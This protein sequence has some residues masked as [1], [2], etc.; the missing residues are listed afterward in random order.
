MNRKINSEDHWKK[1][2]TP[3]EFHI[4]REKGTEPAFIGKLLYNKKRG[5]YVCAACGDK[6]FSSGAKY[7]SGTGWPSFFAPASGKSVKTQPDSAM[8]TEATCSRC[9]SHLGHVFDDGPEPTGQRF[10]INSAA[11]KFKEKKSRP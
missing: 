1:K 5:V 6:L 7:D 2:L 9:G 3:E 11:L 10:C 4:L 8:R